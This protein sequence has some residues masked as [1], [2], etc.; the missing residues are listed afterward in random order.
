MLRKLLTVALFALTASALAAAAKAGPA[1]EFEFVSIEGEPLP[2]TQ[3]AGKTVLL[4]NTASFCGYTYQYDGLQELYETYRDRGLVVLG[5]PSND[6]GRQ[7]PG[8]EAE[9]KEFCE[10]NFSINFPMTEKQVVRGSGAHPLYK[11]I[12][13]ELGES[14][15]PGWNF[16]KYLINADGEVVAAFSNRVRPMSDTIR[17]AV[18]KELKDRG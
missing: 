5:V 3:F 14:Q 1:H 6:F 4:V 10:V 7:E 15:L 18:E 9:I 12:G 17:K 11:W 2:M 13:R 8:S 16:Y